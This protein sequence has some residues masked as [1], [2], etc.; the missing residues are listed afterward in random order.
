MDELSD[1]EKT[2]VTRARHLLVTKTSNV[3]EQFTGQQVSYV[4]V[5]ETGTWL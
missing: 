2:L 5:A 4:P 1:E 3:A